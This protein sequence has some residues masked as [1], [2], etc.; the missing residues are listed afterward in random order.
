MFYCLDHSPQYSNSER[1]DEFIDFTMMYVFFVSVYSITSRNNASISNF[2][3][4]F[5]WKSEYPWCIIEVKSKHFPTAFKKI[6]KNKK[7][8][9]GKTGIFTQNQFLT[10]SI[11][12]YGCNL[13]TNH[14]KYLKFSPNVYVMRL[15]FKFLR[16]RL[17]I[18]IYP[19]TNLNICYFQ[20]T[21]E[22][23]PFKIVF[24]LQRYL[25]L[26][27][28]LTYPSPRSTPPPN[29]QQ[30]DN[31]Y[32]N[33]KLL[34]MDDEGTITI[35]KLAWKLI[36]NLTRNKN[37]I[38]NGTFKNIIEYNTVLKII[39]NFKDKT[40]AGFDKISVKLLKKYSS[41]AP[42]FVNTAF[43]RINFNSPMS[44]HFIKQIKQKMRWTIDRYLCFTTYQVFACVEQQ[45]EYLEKHNFHQSQLSR[46]RL[47]TRH[48]QCN[49]HNK[50]YIHIRLNDIFPTYDGFKA[51]LLTLNS[52][53]N[54]S[55][56]N[57]VTH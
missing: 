5:R 52:K 42:Y 37:N 13:K 19:Q 20:K 39:N 51:F 38:N 12:L 56:Y 3:G 22:S 17:T 15:N 26:H 29:V 44:H 11:F 18:T 57:W 40:A 32:Y 36:H 43:F 45:D 53:I 10:E 7:K 34:N 33:S 9:D 31:Y 6:E 55:S 41:F 2:G 8:N 30:S 28:N 14:C 46:T 25:S 49:T 24:R 4:G 35:P 27:S 54:S 16:K 47:V 48:Q 21:D 23:S 1:S 50:K